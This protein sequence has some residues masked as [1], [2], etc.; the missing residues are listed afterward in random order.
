MKICIIINGK[1][2][3]FDVPLLVDRDI[4]KRPPPPENFPELELAATVLEMV[5][6]V[7]ASELSKQLSDV[8]TRYIGNLQKQLPKDVEIETAERA[9]ARTS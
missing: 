3:C 7:G 2:H 6:F 8:A 1:K 4:F 9:A 5:H